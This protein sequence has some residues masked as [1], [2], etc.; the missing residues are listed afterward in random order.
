MATKSYFILLLILGIH[1]FDRIWQ[2]MLNPCNQASSAG[3]LETEASAGRT[4]KDDGQFISVSQ[5]GATAKPPA[6]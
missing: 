6:A 5:S 3:N 1:P 4:Q 2:C